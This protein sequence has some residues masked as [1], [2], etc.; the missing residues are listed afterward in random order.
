[1][2]NDIVHTDIYCRVS[3]V[4]YLDDIVYL[5]YRPRDELYDLYDTRELVARS[6][7]GVIKLLSVG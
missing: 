4:L 7:L 6:P 5:A 2:L 1:M 3:L